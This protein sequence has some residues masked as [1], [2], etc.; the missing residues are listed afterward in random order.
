MGLKLWIRI[1]VIRLGLYGVNVLGLQL[2]LK[3]GLE[4]A[5]EVGLRLHKFPDPLG[6][7]IYKNVVDNLYCIY[8]PVSK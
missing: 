2:W 8:S 5:L 1:R 4:A 3:F 7:C 6:G